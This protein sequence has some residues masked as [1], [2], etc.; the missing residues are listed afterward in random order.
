MKG[1]L[2]RAVGAVAGARP[3]PETEAT[4]EAEDRLSQGGAAM[5][6]RFRVAGE[7]RRS[8]AGRSHYSAA[9]YNA[10]AFTL[11]AV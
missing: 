6:L 3:S 1:V 2:Q 10:A 7:G 8:G 9:G 5:A 4:A 11:A